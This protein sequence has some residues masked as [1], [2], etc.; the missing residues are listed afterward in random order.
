MMGNLGQTARNSAQS[1]LLNAGIHLQQEMKMAATQFL[2][3]LEKTM[4]FSMS[5]CLL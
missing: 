1:D 2:G 3:G 4:T 5:G